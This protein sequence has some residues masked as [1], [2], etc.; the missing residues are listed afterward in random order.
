MRGGLHKYSNFL[1]FGQLRREKVGGKLG[2]CGGRG[3]G[4]GLF[5]TEEPL[6]QAISAERGNSNIST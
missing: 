2:I 5:E 1:G 3:V 6:E 4:V